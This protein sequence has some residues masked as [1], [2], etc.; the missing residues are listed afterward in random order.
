[1]FAHH[2]TVLD[3]I[4]HYLRDERYEYVRIDG[5]THPTDRHLRVVRFQTD[6]R[7]RVAILAIT[8]GEL[9]LPSSRQSE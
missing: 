1:M 2:R 9:W 3:G 7:C 4:E 5:R 6:A 8:A